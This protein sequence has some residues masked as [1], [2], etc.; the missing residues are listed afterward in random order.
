MLARGVGGGAAPVG[1][2]VTSTPRAFPGASP[3]LPGCSVHGGPGQTPLLPSL[4][5]QVDTLTFQSQSLRDRARRFE[6]ALR[7]NTED[8]LEVAEP[9]RPPGTGAPT[10]PHPRKPCGFLCSPPRQGP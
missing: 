6:D 1:A 2:R 4:Q 3:Q 7:R 5:D 8:Q 9:A 10:G